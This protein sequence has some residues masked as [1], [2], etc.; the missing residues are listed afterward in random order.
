MIL[1]LKCKNPFAN[2]YW[3]RLRY[4]KERF[5]INQTAPSGCRPGLR[6]PAV[7]KG[8]QPLVAPPNTYDQK[9]WRRLIRVDVETIFNFSL[10]KC[11]TPIFVAET[12]CKKLLLLSPSTW[13]W[14]SCLLHLKMKRLIP[15]IVQFSD[16]ND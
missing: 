10:A 1:F 2:I 4:T 14:T 5:P 13:E 7:S 9:A 15:L 12:Y 3:S 8:L 16:K 11:W 6:P